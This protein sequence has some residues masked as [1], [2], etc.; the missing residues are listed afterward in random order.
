[1]FTPLVAYYLT[2]LQILTL[3]NGSI[4]AR[5][6]DP[7]ETWDSCLAYSQLLV[8]SPAPPDVVLIVLSIAPPKKN[9]WKILSAF[10][11]INIYW[12][13]HQLDL[14][15]KQKG[16]MFYP[17]ECFHSFSFVICFC[18]GVMPS[19]SQETCLVVFLT[20]CMILPCMYVSNMHTAVTR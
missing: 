7:K 13:R 18:F 17:S 12:K 14:L 15:G 1:M 4:G 20:S 8:C 5:K 3:K 11:S 19:D 10:T 6:I 9:E 16:I 2:E